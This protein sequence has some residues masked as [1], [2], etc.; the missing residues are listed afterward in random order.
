VSFPDGEV[1]HFTNDPTNYDLC[2]M[3]LTS[4]GKTLA[5]VQNE[6]TANLWTA[7]SSKIDESRQITSG[8]AHRTAVWAAND[9]I[10]TASV[11]GQITQLAADGSD[12]VRLSFRQTPSD[13]PS[14]CGDGHYLV[15]PVSSGSGSEIWRADAADGGNP[16]RLTNIDSPLWPSCSPDGKWVLY[17]V[18][19]N[20]GFSAMRISILGGDPVKLGERVDRPHS[21]ISPD[22]K[23]VVLG[24]WGKT[25]TSPNLF[26]VFALDT[27]KELYSF[28]RTPAVRAFQWAPDGRAIDYALTKNGVGNIWRQALAGDAP[29][30]LTHFESE[31]ISDFDWSPDGKQLVISRGHTNRNV[32]LISNFH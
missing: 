29:K 25:P 31:E 21:S 24:I 10:L 2:C 7:P 8:E 12:P 17:D 26:K 15:Y 23:M 9:R 14:V 4:D 28:D 27:G 5:V 16:V 19:D 20:S 6:V 13:L 30:Q 22:S 18:S 32:L 11:N 1:R 3:D